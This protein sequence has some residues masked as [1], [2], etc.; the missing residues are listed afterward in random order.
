[1]QGRAL[2]DIVQDN[3]EFV[4]MQNNRDYIRNIEG[5]LVIEQENPNLFEDLEHT[6]ILNS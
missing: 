3:A 6:D 2:F 4:R 5:I 1:M